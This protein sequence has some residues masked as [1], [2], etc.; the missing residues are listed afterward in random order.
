M[1]QLESAKN[2]QITREMQIVTKKE[3][4]EESQ[5]LEL[6]AQGQVVIP[7]NKNHV[8][9]QPIGIGKSMRTKINA[10]IGTSGDFQ[11]IENELKPQHRR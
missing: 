6:I 9:L 5:L 3:G 1:T 11:Q 10:N 7:A 2:G 8:N 4:I